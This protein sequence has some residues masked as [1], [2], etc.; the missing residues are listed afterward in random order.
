M[1]LSP[2]VGQW[3]NTE[4]RRPD[5][6]AISVRRENGTVLVAPDNWAE[7]PASMICATAITSAEAGGYVADFASKQ[8][9]ATLNQGLLV[10]VVFDRESRR[11]TREF[12]RRSS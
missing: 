12:F 9:Q 6:S 1:D 10:V 2:L 8:L 5:I 3:I 11:V 4:T 7:S